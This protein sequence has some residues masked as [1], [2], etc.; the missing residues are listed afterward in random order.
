MPETL[1]REIIMNPFLTDAYAPSQSPL[2]PVPILL[3]D[4]DAAEEW[5]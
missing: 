2:S 4:R 5:V 1:Q 3:N